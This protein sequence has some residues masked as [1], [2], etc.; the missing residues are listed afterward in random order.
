MRR[1]VLP[2][3][4]SSVLLASAACAGTPETPVQAAPSGAVT[5][6]APTPSRSPQDSPYKAVCSGRT[7]PWKE[8]FV[9]AGVYDGLVQ[10]IYPGGNGGKKAALADLVKVTGAYRGYLNS[11]A[12]GSTDPK[13]AEAARVDVASLDKSIAGLK[14]VGTDWDGKVA[15]AVAALQQ[16]I[17]GGSRFHMFCNG[18]GL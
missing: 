12:T 11:V 4:F 15:K 13:V 10:G 14:S 3:V 5:S 17:M 8:V 16:S 7:E 6:A 2:L 1:L 9:L 18:E